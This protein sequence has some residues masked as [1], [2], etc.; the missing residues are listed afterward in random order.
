M[1]KTANVAD[2]K[3]GTEVINGNGASKQRGKDLEIHRSTTFQEDA[4]IIAQEVNK[5]T[6]ERRREAEE[7]AAEQMKLAGMVEKN[8]EMAKVAINAFVMAYTMLEA[9]VA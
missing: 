2:G 3:A 4:T 8:A 6:E 7:I 1:L 5:M 9:R